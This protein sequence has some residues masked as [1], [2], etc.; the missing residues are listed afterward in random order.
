MAVE[1]DFFRL[2]GRFGVLLTVTVGIVLILA[3]SSGI[4]ETVVVA[5]AATQSVV[6]GGNMVVGTLHL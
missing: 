3:T 4:K 5:G 2:Y 6:V 1:T